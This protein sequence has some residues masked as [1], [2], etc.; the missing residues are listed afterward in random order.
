MAKFWIRRLALRLGTFWVSRRN[1]QS[2]VESFGLLGEIAWV[3]GGKASRSDAG[4]L[5]VHFRFRG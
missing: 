2:L 5:S 3:F 4:R 1:E